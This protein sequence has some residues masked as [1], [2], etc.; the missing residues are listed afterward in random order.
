[1]LQ[2]QADYFHIYPAGVTIRGRSQEASSLSSISRTRDVKRDES[3]FLNDTERRQE[4][5]KRERK[6]E[7]ITRTAHNGVL[8]IRIDKDSL[9]TARVCGCNK[10]R[11]R[12]PQ[13]TDL[14]HF[15]AG[16]D[17]FR[18]RPCES[19]FLLKGEREANSK[20]TWTELGE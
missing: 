12:S 11:R 10:I 20:F 8:L 6:R 18:R 19:E 16:P 9:R 4:E 17:I 5:R 1:V 14:K 7:V 15:S 2:L 3:Q 13:L